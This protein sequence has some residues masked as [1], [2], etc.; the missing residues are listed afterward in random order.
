[1]AGELR[2][3]AFCGSTRLD[4]SAEQANAVWCLHCCA[5]GPGGGYDDVDIVTLWN[6]R[7]A[8]DALR[9]R[10][11]KVEELGALCNVAMIAAIRE[12]DVLREENAALRLRAENAEAK[13]R[14][15]EGRP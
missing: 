13:L 5:N 4:A 8:E 7:P 15:Q 6:R 14:G 11:D 10:L 2:P 3:C 12:R 1:M 9:A